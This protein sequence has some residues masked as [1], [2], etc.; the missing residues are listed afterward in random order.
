MLYHRGMEKHP[1]HIKNPELQG[2]S[3]DDIEQ[4]RNITG[5]ADVV[6][7]E[8]RER[9]T[10]DI[11]HSLNN[12]H[13]LNKIWRNEQGE[14]HGYLAFEDFQPD[15]AYAKYFATDGTTSE[16]P[17]SFLPDLL[18][19][20]RSLGYKKIHFHGWNPRLN[21]VLEHF[22]FVKTHR[23]KQGML[24]ADH[25]EIRLDE[26]KTKEVFENKYKS[27]VIK[28]VEKTMATLEDEQRKNLEVSYRD[29]TNRLESQEGFQLSDIRKIILKLKLAR[30][31]QRHDTVDISVLVDAIIETPKFIDKDKGGFD[32]LLELHEQKTI[33]KVAEM[34][35][36]KALQ[37]G[38]EEFN[39]YEA[40]F[41]TSSGKYYLARLLNMPHLEEESRY[42]DHCVGT[43][44]SYISKMK[45]GDVEI[46]S[47]RK[48]P[49]INPQTQKLEGDEPIITI[50]YNVRTKVIEQVKKIHDEYLKESDPYF[51]DV[52][53]SLQKL[54]E[55]Q[56]DTGEMR[57]VKGVASSELQNIQVKDYCLYTEN[58]EIDF[59]D[60]DPDSN[61][62]ILKMGNMEITPQTKKEDAIKIMRVVEGVKVEPEELAYGVEDVD[63]YTKAYIG[64]WNIEIYNKI[65][66]FPNITHLY[67]SFP[68]TKIFRYELTT[69]P[70]IQTSEQVKKKLEEKG[71][72]AS[73]YAKD[74]LDKTEFGKES[75]TYK[76]VQ[77]TVEQLGFPQGA[78]TDQIYAKAQELGLKLC[79][80]EVGPQLRLLYPGKDWKVIAMKQ[81]SDHGGV[82]FVFN[83]LSGDSRLELRADSASPSR[84]WFSDRQFVFLAS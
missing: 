56:L 43:S 25:F 1:L 16:N 54:Q 33:E 68:D 67:E 19:N 47:F 24:S 42:M 71:I 9:A 40:L 20:A 70:A 12:N 65:K 55:T 78:T 39:P 80:A 27:H 46:L 31:L 35:K 45:R 69:D 23:E 51:Q 10:D 28:E 34:R 75:K 79:P 8:V 61:V 58:G 82:P 13:Q 36:K 49:K 2:L 32:R 59:R 5:I 77:F 73:E 57:K 50:E 76:L 26:E 37:T 6:P 38:N 72:Y 84:K 7:E 21:K 81:I 74:L 4:V 63:E 64:P 11:I 14:I 66:D 30:Y 22:G 18:S 41:Q 52:V 53:E 29:I 17:F 44:D 48:T 62:F 15:E 83:L 60:F 3:Q